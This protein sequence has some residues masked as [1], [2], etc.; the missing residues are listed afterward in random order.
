MKRTPDEERVLERM[1]PGVLSRDGFLGADPRPLNEILA[2]DQAEVD[3]LGVTHAAIAARLRAVL[4]AARDAFGRSV[5][6]GE[7]LSAVYHEAMGRI[8]SPW[9]GEGVFPKGEI[10]LADQRSGHT[11]CYTP[12]SVH[13]IEAH[14]F[15]EGRGSRYRLEPSEICRMLGLGEASA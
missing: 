13:L 5:P 11:I 6:V 12:L 1:A 10:E 2:T 3:G 4:L 7:G 15:Y 9:P 8:P 14:G